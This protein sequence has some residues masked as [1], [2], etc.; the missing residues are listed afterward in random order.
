MENGATARVESAN[1]RHCPDCIQMMQYSQLIR[2][3]GPRHPR[4]R[5]VA[6]QCPFHFLLPVDWILSRRQLSRPCEL[7]V[8]WESAMV[9]RWRILRSSEEVGWAVAGA[10]RDAR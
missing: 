8:T 9:L 10:C 2:N 7:F 3:G 1:L 5:R 6:R 4:S